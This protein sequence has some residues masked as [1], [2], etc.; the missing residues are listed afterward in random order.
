VEGTRQALFYCLKKASILI[1]LL[2]VTQLAVTKLAVTQLALTQPALTQLAVNNGHA[3]DSRSDYFFFF[4][5][6][7]TRAL[8]LSVAFMK[9]IPSSLRSE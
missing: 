3:V 6:F 8:F 5:I 1:N 9:I 4:E 7:E 2:N